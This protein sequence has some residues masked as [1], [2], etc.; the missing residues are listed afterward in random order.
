MGLRADREPRVRGRGAAR[1]DAAPVTS[2]TEL[3]PYHVTGDRAAAIAIG[4]RVTGISWVFEPDGELGTLWLYA[5]AER[6]WARVHLQASS[7]HLVEQ[8]GSRQL[9]NEVVGGHRWWR[10][11]GEPGVRDWL[12]KV[13]RHGH[14][15]TVDPSDT[16]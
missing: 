7:P 3:H 11:S 6:S 9:W 14:R 5:P 10:D 1:S 13:D 8:A 2:T 16:R 4:T 12:V 15:M